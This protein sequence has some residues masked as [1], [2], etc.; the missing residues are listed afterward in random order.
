M[1][2]FTDKRSRA[3]F[4]GSLLVAFSFVCA[5]LA[6][7]SLSHTKLIVEVQEINSEVPLLAKKAEVSNEGAVGEPLIEEVDAFKEEDP[8]PFVE[9]FVFMNDDAS[10]DVAEPVVDDSVQEI[11]QP[12]DMQAALNLIEKLENEDAITIVKPLAEESESLEQLQEIQKP[13]IAIQSRDDEALKQ[14]ALE[15]AMNNVSR[16]VENGIPRLVER[17]KVMEE[18]EEADEVSEEAPVEEPEEPADEVKK[19]QSQEL[20]LREGLMWVDRKES[21]LIVTLGHEHGVTIGDHMA[22]FQ[23]GKEIGTVR[24]DETLDMVSYVSPGQ[25]KSFALTEDYYQVKY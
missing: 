21:K 3:I 16:L 18:K 1:E 10:L 2:L 15:L 22:V 11:V 13:V 8:D 14:D 19:E 12:A 24:V 5:F 7:S 4:I 6:F 25:E 23:N 17:K 20:S 9:T